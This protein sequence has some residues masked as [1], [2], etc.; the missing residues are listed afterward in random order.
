MPTNY[1]RANLITESSTLF[2]DNNSQLISPADLRQWL[3]DGTTSFVT[4]KDK[5]TLENSI[6]EAQASTLVA[7]S[8]VNLALASGNYLHISGTGTINSFGTCPAGARFILMFEAAATLIYN[9]TSLIIPG[10]TNKTVVAG[11]CC[12]ILSEGGGNW[13]IVGYFVGAGI[14]SGTITG[15]TAGTGLSGGGTSGGV[16]LNLANTAVTPAAYTNANITIDPQG[17]ITSASSGTPGGVTSVSVNAPLSDAGT[18]TAPDISISKADGLTDGYL[19]KDDFVDFAGKQDA[20][21]AGTGISLASNIVTNTAPDQTVSLASGTGIGITGTYPSFTIANTS[22]SSGGTIT[23]LTGDVTASGSGSVASTLSNTT[24]TAGSYTNTNITVDSKGRIT[25]AANGTGGGGVSSV[26]ATSPITSS[27]GSTPTIST[28]M[29]TNKLVGRYGAGTGIMQEVTIGSGLTLTG[30]GTLNN[31]AT[32]TPLGYYAMYQSVVTQTAA[33]NNTGYAMKF[34]TMD[35]SNQVTVANNGSGDPTRITFANAGVY[36]LQFSSQFQNADNE[37]HDI[38]I[39]IKLNGTDIAGSTGFISVPARKSAGAG[40][41]GHVIAGWNY[42]LDVSAGQYYEIVWSTSNAANVTMQ[43]YPGSTPPPSTASTI[44]TVTQQSGI[45]AGSGI[46]SINSLTG[47]AQT[48]ATGT[49]GTDF[50]IVS[51]GTSHTL[52]L[53]DASASARGV[54]TSAAQTLAGI[55]TFGNGAS[56]GE[57]RLLEG[58]GSGINYVALKSPSTLGA[59]LS[60]TFPNTTPGTGQALV[61][62]SSGVLSWSSNPGTTNAIYRRTYGGSITGFT[63]ETLLQSLLVPANTLTDGVGFQLMT[64]VTR[65]NAGSN[66]IVIK[67]YINTSAAIGGVAMTSTGYSAAAN[68]GAPTFHLT[69]LGFIQVA[70]GGSKNTVFLPSATLTNYAVGLGALTSSPIDWAVDQYFV[71]TVSQSVSAS[72]ITCNSMQLLPQ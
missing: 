23:A 15:V 17:R 63:A 57:I 25:A 18:A 20:L 67:L 2:P 48:I 44:F 46:T 64:L 22:P 62:D 65:T 19:D 42:L 4:Q 52:N 21:S 50:A 5:S 43:Y 24:V 39:W 54:I 14:G 70:T 61:S 66:A 27:G 33:F 12:L 55:K 29:A 11:D 58:S 26:A 41:E 51:S 68:A 6:Y 34:G 28:S 38:S 49:S 71:L 36:N 37:Q 40:N 1:N 56:A 30:A 9:A 8:T 47:A 13:R 69:R 3:E 72:T 7:G 60:L 16:T 32:P 45:M 31:T 35:L 53:P 10:G 59:D